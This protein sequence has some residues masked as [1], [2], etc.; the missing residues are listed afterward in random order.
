MNS[1]GRSCSA[2][3]RCNE[4]I[5]RQTSFGHAGGIHQRLEAKRLR[6][7]ARRYLS[8]GWHETKRGLLQRRIDFVGNGHRNG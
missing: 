8:H 7:A 2:S 5:A 6:D 4:P 3:F 1:V